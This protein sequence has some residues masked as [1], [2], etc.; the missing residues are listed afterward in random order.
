MTLEELDKKAPAGAYSTKDSAISVPY[1]KAIPKN[2]RYVEVGVDRGKSLWI[3]RQVTDPS[4]EVVGVDIQDPPGVVGTVF[5]QQD[6]KLG[7]SEDME[8][9]VLFIDG[10]HSYEGCKA[11]IEAWYPYVKKGGVMLFHDCDESSPGV[12]Q[13]VAEF[14]CTHDYTKFKLT[15]DPRCSMGV[16][17]V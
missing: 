7:P 12:V 13:A 17:E 1:M 3:A 4:V 9:D 16:I 14:I 2:G 10:D 11:D 6:S 5:Y 15:K 8:I